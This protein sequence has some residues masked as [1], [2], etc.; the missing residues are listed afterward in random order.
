MFNHERAT[1]AA[2][3]VS[4]YPTFQRWLEISGTTRPEFVRF[5]TK[6]ARRNNW[7]AAELQACLSWIS[8]VETDDPMPP[9]LLR[10]VLDEMTSIA[11]QAAAMT[12]RLSTLHQA[13]TNLAMVALGECTRRCQDAT[14]TRNEHRRHGTEFDG[15]NAPVILTRRER[16]VLQLVGAGN[17]NRQIARIL[18]LAEQTV[19]NHLTST[20][21]KLNAADRTSAVLAAL[22][23][24]L[25]PDPTE[26]SPAAPPARSP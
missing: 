20:F 22:R 18:G 7:P 4:T 10:T 6:T 8:D 23:Q 3:A 2:V 25:I 15:D 11:E 12:Q 21:T 13:G 19:K 16:Q 17:S 14:R 5:L 24:R 26:P 9:R 1:G